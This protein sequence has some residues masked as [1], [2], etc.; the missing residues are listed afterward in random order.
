MVA[1][2]KRS[3]GGSTGAKS[4]EWI[5][6]SYRIPREPS[7][8]RIAVWRKLKDLGVAQLGDGLVALPSGPRTREDLEWVA[9]QVLE[10]GGE[11]MVWVATPTARRNSSDISGVMREARTAEYAALAAEIAAERRSAG[12]RTIARWRRQWRKIDRRDHHGSPGRDEVRQ[13]I[14]EAAQTPVHLVADR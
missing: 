11:A 4:Q 8:P 1:Q 3:S 9:A 14:A 12:P 5:L 13:A 6:L 10:A 7:T 2:P